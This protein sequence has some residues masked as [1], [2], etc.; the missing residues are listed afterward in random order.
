MENCETKPVRSGWRSGLFKHVGL[1]TIAVVTSGVLMSRVKSG[2]SLEPLIWLAL[3]WYLGLLFVVDFLLF[4]GRG[5]IKTLLVILT[6]VAVLIMFPFSAIRKAEYRARRLTNFAS[7]GRL[8]KVQL[9]KQW[10]WWELP[11]G[12]CIPRCLAWRV[13]VNGIDR[14]TLL[15]LEANEFQDFPKW[16]VDE[17]D[18]LHIRLDGTPPTFIRNR[19][20]PSWLDIVGVAPSLS[21]QEK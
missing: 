9:L 18:R 14:Q 15:I 11:T 6:G 1:I 3:A 5:R 8:E 13:P 10:D 16:F 7:Q 12:E 2:W 21:L 19:F 4:R 20:A 17:V